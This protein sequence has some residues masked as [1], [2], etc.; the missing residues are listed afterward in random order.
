MCR[1]L[2]SL[3]VRVADQE[4]WDRRLSGGLRSDRTGNATGTGINSCVPMAPGDSP[5]TGGKRDILG[6]KMMARPIEPTP[7]LDIKNSII[8]HQKM[9]SQEKPEIRISI[10]KINAAIQKF[11]QQIS[12]IS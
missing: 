5:G 3:R 2:R 10:S 1:P 11:E 12:E 7:A 9:H 8:F 4:R 6:G